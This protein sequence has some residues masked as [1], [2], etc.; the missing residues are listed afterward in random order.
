MQ[1]EIIDC[2]NR[3]AEIAFTYNNK[4]YAI[5][6]RDERKFSVC[7]LPKEETEIIY[8]TPQEALTYLC[9]GKP[10]HDILQDMQVIDRTL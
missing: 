3:G 4:I 5:E 7:E 9:S 2:L 1:E 8:T 10:I 6:K